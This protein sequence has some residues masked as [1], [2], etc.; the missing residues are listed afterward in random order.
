LCEVRGR[1]PQTIQI[2]PK[3]HLHFTNERTRP[4]SGTSS[5]IVEDLQAYAAVGVGEIILY[6][7]GASEAEKLDNLHRIAEE[8]VPHVS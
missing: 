3:T 2:A 6:V 4:M 7:P 1:D 5:Q 8:I